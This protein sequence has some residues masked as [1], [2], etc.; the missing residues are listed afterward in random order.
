MV[1]GGHIKR[2]YN[3]INSVLQTNKQVNRAEQRIQKD[4]SI[5]GNLT[6]SKS[7]IS[8]QED[9]NRFFNN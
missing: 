6:L 3:K 1:K 4:I 7:A 8:T 9:K 5:W 2:H